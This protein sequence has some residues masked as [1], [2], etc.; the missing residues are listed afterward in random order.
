M[1]YLVEVTYTDKESQSL[2]SAYESENDLLGAVET[3]LGQAMKSE[4]TKV[5]YLLAFDQ[6][7]KIFAE[8]YHTKDTSII[9][10]NRLV[11]VTA[12]SNGETPNMQKY[13]SALEAEAN[14]HIKRGSA[15]SNNDVQ[16]ILAMTINA[17]G[18]VLNSYYVKPA[19]V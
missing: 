12:D 4:A 7:G 18:V 6:T 17:A 5:E 1:L 8:E 11:W 15:M 16:A 3:K 9:L 19:I 13:D 14:Y 2:Y 10:S